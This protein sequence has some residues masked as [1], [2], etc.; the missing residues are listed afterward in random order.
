MKA[1]RPILPITVFLAA[2]SDTAVDP[3]K[4]RTSLDPNAVPPG[5][6]N[7]AIPNFSR[8]LKS[9]PTLA[10]ATAGAISP[11]LLTATL[12]PGQTVAEHK[13]VTL[14][15]STPRGDVLFVFDLTGSMG[16]AINNVK[17]N[18]VNIMNAVRGVITDV[19]FGLVTHKDY[20]GRF[21]SSIAAGQ[22]CNYDAFYGGTG[23]FAYR[24]DQPVT[25]DNATV[26]NALGALTAGG[27]ADGPESYARVLY[28][29]YA[30]PLIGWRDGAKRVVVQFGDNVPHD[31]TLGKGNDP[32]RDNV[33]GTSDDLFVNDV[34]NGMKNNGV[35]MVSVHNGFNNTLWNGYATITGGTSFQINTNGTFP[36]GVDPA[37]KIAELINASVRTLRSLTLQVCAEHTEQFGRWLVSV[38]PVSYSNVVL[39][40]SREFDIVVGPPAGDLANGDYRFDICAMGD[41][42]EYGRQ[43]VTITNETTTKA[44]PRNNPEPVTVTVQEG[45]KNVAGVSI[46]AGT[47]DEDV[48]VTVQFKKVTATAQC[49]D[50]LLGQIGRCV[51]I[52][53]TGASGPA[54]LFKDLIVGL[55]L[56]PTGPIQVDLFKFEEPRGRAIP[57]Q[58][59]LA[60]FLDCTGFRNASLG[61]PK[62]GLAAFAA[63]F[64]DRVSSW[65]SPR[66]LWAADD[67]FGGIIPHGLGLSTFT[68]AYPIPV[69]HANLGVN[70][71]NT[72]YDVFEVSGVFD[73]G[74]KTF[75][76]FMGEQG[77]DPAIH[78]VTIGYGATY[79]RLDPAKFR[80]LPLLK[81]WVYASFQPGAGVRSMVID[82]TG[83]FTVA[84]AVPTEGGTGPTTRAFTLQ[85]GNR[86]RGAILLCGSDPNVFKC[87]L[88]H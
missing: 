47:F 70:V 85:I 31:C 66:S 83:S 13:T 45:G 17:T 72:G 4:R 75:D 12:A 15:T 10:H 50:L 39:G 49:H 81:R 88:T 40:E 53:A 59:T 26:A 82:A 69:A 24:R 79:F 27:G 2:C 73:L 19:N 63:G 28:E 64:V 56:D 55:C 20:N 43:H 23:D 18:A 46:P 5:A 58:E 11:A 67:G 38:T 76:P 1:L 51:E 61:A 22:T 25:P 68:Y 71:A 35:T 52:K 77:F 29:T 6:V 84:G 34:L 62:R 41:G 14:P 87:V 32:G 37:A 36:T 74:P 60:S 86:I 80:Y 57:L 42:V 7:E 30:D 8:L 65:L 44:I 21:T 48:T 33:I 9:R 3:A 16:G 54:K 78:P